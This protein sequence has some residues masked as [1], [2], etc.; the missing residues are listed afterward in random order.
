MQ[1]F[2]FTYSV[3]TLF[4]VFLLPWFALP[5]FL[6]VIFPDASCFAV[7]AQ[8][9]SPVKVKHTQKLWGKTISACDVETIEEVKAPEPSVSVAKEVSEPESEKYY[10]LI[11]NM[12][13]R[14]ES[15]TD[16]N[17]IKLLRKGEEFQVLDEH[18]QDDLNTWHFIKSKSDLKGWICGIYRG[19]NMFKEK[20]EAKA[21]PAE[22]DIS[23]AR[24]KKLVKTGNY[25][26]ALSILAPF[27]S[28]PMK[29]P[30]IFSD[31]LV[32][33]L[34]D[35]RVDAAI[36]MYEALSSS[37]PRRA[38]LLRNMAKAYYDREKFLK[39][40]SL[41]QAALKQTPLDE[42][43]QNGLVLSYI[44]AD[45]FE[46]A[47][48]YLERF[49]K[50]VPDSL[51]LTRTKAHLLI[52]QGRYLEG[53]RMYQM[54]AKRKY[55]ECE[56]I[57]KVIASL[58][59][60][61]RKDMLDDLLVAAQQGD[62]QA[63]LDSMLV[64]RSNRNYKGTVK[65]FET[66]NIDFK[67]Y[68]DDLVCWIAWAYFKTGGIK[69][70]KQYF[71]KVLDARPDYVQA[72]IGLTYCLTA[73]GQ[74]DRA[75][76]ILD[77]LLLVE[78]QNVEIRFAR[79]FVHK[80]ARR[81]LVAVREYDRLLEISPENR[82][83]RKL[84]LRALSDLGASSY[85][86]EEAHREFPDALEFQDSIKGDMAVD[87]INW[88]E[89]KEGI[90]LLS[91]LVKKRENL[92]YR[93]DYLTA[94]VENNQM[95]EAVEDYE[96]LVKNG[97]SPPPWT[98]DKVAEAYLYLEE[99]YKALELY[100]E[101]LKA[102][103]DSFNG[104]MGKFYTLQEIR[105]W[106]EARK[107]L[108]DLDQDTPKVLGQGKKAR[109]NW[110]KLETVLARGWLFADEDRLSEAEEFFHNLYERAP[111]NTGIRNGLAH[112]HLWRG[113]PRKALKEFRIIDTLDPKYLK[114]QTGKITALNELAFK[115][116]AREE[117]DR[118]LSTHPKDKDVQRLCRQLEVEEM[119]ELVTKFEI[120]DEEG[121]SEDISAEITLYEPL[122]LYTTLY[123]TLLWQK[124]WEDSLSR[125]FRRAGIGIKHIFNSS[126]SLKQQFSVNYDDGGDFGSL[127]QVNFYPDDYW[128]FNLS[129]DSFT[130]DIPMRARVY[131]IEGDKSDLTMTYRESEWRS[132]HISL[133]HSGFSD[134]NNRQSA[135]LGYEQGLWVKNNWK[136]RLFL[137]LYMSRNSR[138]DVPYFNPDN[139][140]SLSATHMTEQT[141]WRIYGRAFVH[142]L[143]LTLGAYK[144]SGF[145][146]AAIVSVRYEQDHKFSDVHALLWGV[147]LD[148]N[149]YDGDSVNS[150]SLDLIY[151]WRF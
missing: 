117:A 148:R 58:S 97:V 21:K 31:Y 47:S 105:E 61:E 45:D 129:Y 11:S 42:E 46:K 62:E 3:R 30:T 6:S 139:D 37:F 7:Y 25:K 109:P 93:F 72:K 100:D 89:P 126:W 94:L 121:G 96:T 9:V 66:V 88:K 22:A 122:S 127:T 77:R 113:W 116:D 4:S 64:L 13:L 28:K 71:Q 67:R 151:R 43:A 92:R 144:Q 86:L 2:G 150:W 63:Y 134:D 136:M 39:A 24:A 98:L 115:E 34:W 33:L 149:V 140:L 99:P 91:P 12:N 106:D 70:A 130:T 145:S 85:A 120:T 146:N 107:M 59:I 128:S 49:I 95:E 137:D 103:P 14:E 141:L 81:F 142:R 32:I 57:H 53:L 17:I 101:A 80:K 124:T 104:R 55:I 48:D 5:T 38:Y 10:I 90:S 74:G 44:Q 131:D 78:P 15:N 20:L 54:L 50:R 52:R 82:V 8:T 23:I 26:E 69:Q 68:S 118:L 111:A 40:A 1:L 110:P 51:S 60:E 36:S 19:K 87:R 102:Y 56:H 29:Y 119:R 16:S 147:T 135:L 112:V 27:T 84:R 125:Y 123:G 73:E 132:Y 65:A 18:K 75:L 76:E 138:D 133:S 143:F 79:A 83:A 114:A 41:Y 35:G 108:D